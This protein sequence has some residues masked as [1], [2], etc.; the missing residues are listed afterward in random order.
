[1]PVTQ[2]LYWSATITLLVVGLVLWVR[3]LVGGGAQRWLD[4]SPRLPAWPIG[5]GDFLLLPFFVVVLLVFAVSGMSWLVGADQVQA[6]TSRLLLAS[7]ASMGIALT[8]AAGAFR[9]LP[10]GRPGESREGVLRCIGT[11]LLAL[12]YFMP[13]GVGLRLAWVFLLERIGLPADL[14]DVVG[15]IAGESDPLMLVLWFVVVVGLAPLGEEL[16]F[17]AGVFRFLSNRMRPGLAMAISAALFAGIHLNLQASLPLFAFGVAL[18]Q[19]YH[20][21]GRIIT[22]IV[23]HAAF[24][25]TTMLAIVSGVVN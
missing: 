16:V 12:L 20:K 18:A 14:Q 19:V 17:R 7:A 3:A 8:L 11:G 13:V 22:S 21:T 5:W 25:L 4:A 10:V 24:N 9:L 15:V 6:N 2:A 1:M 23:L